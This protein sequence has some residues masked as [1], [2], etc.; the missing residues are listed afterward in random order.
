MS[1]IDGLPSYYRKSQVVKD[2]YNA[3]QSALEKFEGDMDTKAS[4]LFVLTASDLSLHEKDVGLTSDPSIHEETRRAQVLAR[5]Q[6][7]KLLTISELKS[8]INLY[9]K[10]GC[11]INEDF[12]N[13][14]VTI[15]FDGRKG[16]P[17]NFEQLKAAIDE[18]K[19]AHLNFEYE[20]IRNTWGDCHNKLG[21]WGR[22][23]NYT[24]GGAAYYDGRTWLFVADNGNVYQQIEN[25]NAYVVFKDGEPY[26]RFL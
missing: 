1:M 25:A 24:W 6:G 26:A 2:L 4:N 9:D 22:G 16:Q 13:Y 3:I 21:T 5:L 11:S 8:L 15:V 7:H 14:T 20:F 19:P 17:Y 12:E 18:V 10:T 23:V